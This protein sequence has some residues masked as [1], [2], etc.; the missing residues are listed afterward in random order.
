[1][2]EKLVRHSRDRNENR[3]CIEEWFLC[4]LLKK[5]KIVHFCS[6]MGK[7]IG[8]NCKLVDQLSH[9]MT[10][11]ERGRDDVVLS[12]SVYSVKCLICLLLLQSTQRYFWA[13]EREKIAR[14]RRL[15][16]L[17]N[18]TIFCHLIFLANGCTGKMWRRP[19]AEERAGFRFSANIFNVYFIA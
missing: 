11:L 10:K 6:L 4:F 17:H 14:L 3:F 18:F 5:T 9:Q 8:W 12:L 13:F 7:V 19:W 2:F 16:A 15:Y 1:M